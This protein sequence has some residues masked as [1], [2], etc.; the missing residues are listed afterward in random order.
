MNIMDE[1]IAIIEEEMDEPLEEG[2]SIQL[3]DDLEKD[4]HLNSLNM[5]VIINEIED[6]FKLNMSMEDL[7]S[8]KTVKDIE[9]KIKEYTAIEE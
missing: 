3:E 6:R 5:I 7:E 9:D 2:R 1:I 8:I 4:L